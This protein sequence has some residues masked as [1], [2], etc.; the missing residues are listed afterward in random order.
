MLTLKLSEPII[1]TFQ[2]PITDPINFILPTFKGFHIR[3]F[4]C[5]Y[6]NIL[7]NNLNLKSYE[8]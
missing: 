5:K 7:N 2:A 3:G 4:I 1:D 8:P 6:L